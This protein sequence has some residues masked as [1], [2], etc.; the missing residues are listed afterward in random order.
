MGWGPLGELSYKHCF[1][2][3]GPPYVQMHQGVSVGKLR[4]KADC[5]S[6][7]NLSITIIGFNS[8]IGNNSCYDVPGNRVAAPIILNHRGRARQWTEHFACITTCRS[9]NCEVV[10]QMRWLRLS[11]SYVKSQVWRGKWTQST[12]S[13]SGAD[14]IKTP[15]CLIWKSSFLTIYIIWT[16]EEINLHYAGSGV[17]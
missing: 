8:Y 14:A 5:K 6:W 3:G 9:W 2:S 13:W 15:V 17:G 16:M 10:L 11:T 1:L 7:L 4:F 12:R